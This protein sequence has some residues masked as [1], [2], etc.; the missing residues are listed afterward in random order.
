[1]R[2]KKPLIGSS[3][4]CL[5]CGATKDLHRHHIF[6]G[7]NR[8]ASEKYNLTCYLCAR[9]HNMSDEGVH[10][11]SDLDMAIKQCAQAVFEKEHSHEEF[12][13]IIGRNYLGGTEIDREQLSPCG[14]ADQGSGAE[15]RDKIP[16]GL[17]VIDDSC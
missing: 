14:K 2:R 6:Y 10:F 12:M 7:C 16:D 11:K 3:E 1:M 17:Y 15:V 8:A 9:H 13:A 4:Y 5:V